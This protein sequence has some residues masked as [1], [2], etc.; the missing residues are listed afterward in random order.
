MLIT[1]LSLSAVFKEIDFEIKCCFTAPGNNS[2]VIH[3][4]MPFN[5]KESTTT[6]NNFQLLLRSFI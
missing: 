4:Q 1:K 6:L 5:I 2:G 3:A